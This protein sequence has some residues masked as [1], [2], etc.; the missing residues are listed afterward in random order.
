MTDRVTPATTRLL[1][2]GLWAAEDQLPV[3]PQEN[4]ETDIRPDEQRQ[5]LLPDEN[6]YPPDDE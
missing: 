1:D 4:A 5:V 2:R 6:D 3:D